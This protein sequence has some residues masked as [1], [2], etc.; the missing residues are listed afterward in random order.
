MPYIDQP[1]RRKLD[2]GSLPSNPGE[3]TYALTLDVLNGRDAGHL[4]DVLMRY[5]DGQG[6]CFQTFAEILGSLEAT[7]LELCR[8]RMVSRDR[9]L[10]PLAQLDRVK[11]RFY[12]EVVGVYE[13]AK[14][15]LNGDIYQS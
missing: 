7:K 14:I 8:R 10:L 4:A 15:E 13:D 9:L 3:L 5:V 12:Y 1:S 11:R 6:Q 2:G